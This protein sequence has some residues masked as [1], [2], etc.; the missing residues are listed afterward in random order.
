MKHDDLRFKT[1]PIHH[2]VTC[3][4]CHCIYSEYSDP[5]AELGLCE[6]HRPSTQNRINAAAPKPELDWWEQFCKERE[7]SL[8]GEYAPK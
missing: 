7:E 1:H 6:E 8:G 2:L 5:R 4:V 3:S